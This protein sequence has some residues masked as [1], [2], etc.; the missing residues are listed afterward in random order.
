MNPNKV[1]GVGNEFGE[2]EKC[3]YGIFDENDESYVY[4]G[5]VECSA[6]NGIFLKCPNYVYAKCGLTS[7]L[8]CY[9]K[10]EIPI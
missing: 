6:P 2:C 10:G 1:L 9:R 3:L 7:R 4:E 8:G 5:E